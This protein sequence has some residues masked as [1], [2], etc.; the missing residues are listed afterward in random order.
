M[1]EK[2]G[3]LGKSQGLVGGREAVGIEAFGFGEAE[4]L[5]N[6]RYLA[7]LLPALGIELGFEITAF[8]EVAFKLGQEEARFAGN[9]LRL[10][11]S[12]PMVVV[13]GE[14][15]RFGRWRMTTTGR[16]S[17]VACWATW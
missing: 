17:R 2:L 14:V 6:G 3:D 7:E 13:R 12:E 5:A 11:Y 9:D 15:I 10:Q 8:A 1:V 4:A 16:R